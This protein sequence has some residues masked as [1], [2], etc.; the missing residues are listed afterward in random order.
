MASESWDSR[1]LTPRGP[2][3]GV[4]AR[5]DSQ[6]HSTS[7]AS[8]SSEPAP[9]NFCQFFAAKGGP[10]ALLQSW[11]QSS[12]KSL[13]DKS[14]ESSRFVTTVKEE[15]ALITNLAPCQGRTCG[16]QHAAARTAGA[17]GPPALAGP[18]CT[19]N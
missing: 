12:E 4:T 16:R 9:G 15:G 7:F 19:V 18:A 2:D 17:P 3:D 10:A 5:P 1:R 13:S 14:K 6:K 11:E 8:V